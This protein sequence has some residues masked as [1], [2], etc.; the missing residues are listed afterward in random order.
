[1]NIKR[2]YSIL[3][4]SFKKAMLDSIKCLNLCS[5]PIAVVVLEPPVGWEEGAVAEPKMPLSCQF[6]FYKSSRLL[7]CCPC[8]NSSANLLSTKALCFFLLSIIQRFYQQHGSSILPP[9]EDQRGFPHRWEAREV[10]LGRLF[11]RWD[12]CGLDIWWHRCLCVLMV[13]KAVTTVKAID[14]TGGQSIEQNGYW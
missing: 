4:H 10:P 12:R 5:Q 7:F 6:S 13:T 9:E 1:M 3:H 14:R 11:P 8:Q 2:S